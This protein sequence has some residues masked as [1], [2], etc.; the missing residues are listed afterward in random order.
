MP[1]SSR[2]TEHSI[3]SQ[4]SQIIQSFT[5][6]GKHHSFKIIHESYPAKYTNW[7]QYRHIGKSSYKELTENF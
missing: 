2:Y 5:S 6:D 1:E 7:D 3:T 4:V